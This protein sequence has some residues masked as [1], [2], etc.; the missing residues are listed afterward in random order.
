MATTRARDLYLESGSHWGMTGAHG[1]GTR[2]VVMGRQGVVGSAHWLASQEAL[3]V[4]QDG[5]NAFD[6]SVCAAAVVSIA[7]PYM[8]GI[9]GAGGAVC[10]DAKSGKCH[11]LDFHGFAPAAATPDRWS[12]Q[13]DLIDGVGAALVPA[14]VAG[15]AALI[16]RFGT[17][18]LG[19][20][21]A[22]AVRC[23]REGVPVSIL[24]AG[25]IAASAERLQRSEASARVFLPGGSPLRAGQLL[26]QPQ[27]ADTLATIA[28]EGASAF[29]EGSVAKALV[30]GCAA[31]GGLL[32]LDD[33]A[34]ASA[35][36]W[37][38]TASCLY[39]GLSVNTL[40]P[41]YASFQVLET[42]RIL[43]G[44]DLG[45]MGHHSADQLHTFIEAV[46]LARAD[47]VSFP[48]DDPSANYADLLSEEHVARLRGRI[49]PRVA[50]VSSGDWYS[51]SDV[52]APAGAAEL[53]P[54]HTTHLVTADSDGNLVSL[55]QTLGWLFGG[56]VMVGE[57]GVL[58]NDMCYWFDLDRGS[59][60]VIG[61]RKKM[62]SPI[63]PVVVLD[64][65]GA[66]WMTV[67]TPGGHG[68]LQ[69]TAQ[70]ISNTID[71]GLNPQA[72][73]EAARVR[74]DEGRYLAV[75]S[76]IPTAVTDELSARGHE[77]HFV[78]DWMYSPQ[79]GR[80]DIGRGSMAIVDAEESMLLAG[81]DPRGDGFALGV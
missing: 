11:A 29:Y 8:S 49:D 25:Q 73:V 31:A 54:K 24:C 52:L 64:E 80:S 39:R 58:L 69:T 20:L 78:G 33:L 4:L 32:T 47:R 43:E 38:E 6:A 30:A 68:I 79:D 59:P 28:R 61:P 72:A 15:W 40:P 26:V 5:G 60:N 75:E 36:P 19:R 2:S 27:L 13:E 53:G 46:K 9:G 42:L 34:A 57:T 10:F 12:R 56:G 50:S 51:S 71:F 74:A 23:A 44:F 37:L 16:D 77:C 17:M 18:D 62:G 21:L 55:T 1:G 48:T 66:P 7:E 41:P 22:P 81:S 76:R 35:A 67:G 14:V 45:A 65:S 3:R 63:A 70:M